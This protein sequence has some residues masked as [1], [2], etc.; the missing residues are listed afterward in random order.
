MGFI[1]ERSS[2]SAVL[3]K[4]KENCSF[5]G[6]RY[7]L[8]RV[9]HE[10][11]F[12]YKNRQKKLYIYERRDILEQR[13]TYS[14]NILKL[15]PQNKT[16]IYMDETWVNAHHTNEY[17]WVDSDGKGGWKV[18]SGKGQQLIAVHAGG[19]EGC[20]EGA[21][22][23]FGSKTNSA[24]YHKMNSEHFMEWFQDNYCPTYRTTQL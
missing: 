9:L 24:D 17:I 4:V 18:P 15:R 21:E 19:A 7:C 8:W 5:S 11:G 1:K 22:L 2:L 3:E 10:M 13:H 12:S 23:V 16:L 6:G 20:V 14:Q